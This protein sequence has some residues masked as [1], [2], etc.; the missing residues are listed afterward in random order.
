MNKI[1]VI[2]DN[3]NIL[4]EV[5]IWLNLEGYE[6]IGA[7]NGRIG[8]EQALQVHP[9][10]ILCDIMMPEKDGYRVLLELRTQPT[11][12]L[13]PFLFMTAKQEK[14]DIRYG[15]ELGAD[16]YITKPFSHAELLGAVRSRLARRNLFE[17]QSDKRVNE[18]RTQLLYTLPHELRTPLVGILGI[19]E[20]LS[21]DAASLTPDEIID[22]ASLITASGQQL[23]R[24]VENHLLYAQLEVYAAAPERGPLLDLTQTTAVVD[25][26]NEAAMQAAHTYDRLDDLF[27]EVRPGI[28]QLSREDL[29]KIVYELVDNAFKFSKVP[30]TVRIIGGPEA[31]YY[32]FSIFDQGRG[33]TAENI[34]QI[35]PYKQ[36]ERAT[37]EQQG[38]GLGLV[39]ARC[40]VEM[41]G[42]QLN[43]ESTPGIGTTLHIALPL[44]R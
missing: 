31:G 35:G 43:I 6:A 11:T 42:G 21:Q 19:G 32:R 30:A 23:Y 18:L 26:M 4:E 9:D 22:Y 44:G 13:T 36:F 33:L 20:L 29:T 37:Y 12:A 15:M 8:V 14:T 3:V 38:S 5:L 10:L 34:A 39:I 27:L 28:V 24:L 16:D 17:Q 1:L 25:V 2:E 41:A 7:A 40:L